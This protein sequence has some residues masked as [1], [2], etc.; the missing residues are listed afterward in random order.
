MNHDMNY[1][2]KIILEIFNKILE[3]T[4]KLLINI[5]IQCQHSVDDLPGALQTRRTPAPRADP[6][7]GV[8]NGR[9]RQQQQE[10][11]ERA[12]DRR[13][14]ERMERIRE[15]DIILTRYMRERENH[16]NN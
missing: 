13:R 14:P 15:N 2:L 10:A 4:I 9:D 7:G 11:F 6:H 12:A 1:S 3:H 8:E 16:Q 5:L